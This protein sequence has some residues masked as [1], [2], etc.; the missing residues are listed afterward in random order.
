MNGINW[1]STV[2]AFSEFVP[3]DEWRSESGTRFCRIIYSRWER[4][5]KKK[6][7]W[8]VD[9]AWLHR[10]E[11]YFSR[12]CQRIQGLSGLISV[13]TDEQLST[14]LE[15]IEMADVM[16]NIISWTMFSFKGD[17]EG[18]DWCAEH[19]PFLFPSHSLIV[20]EKNLFNEMEFCFHSFIHSLALVF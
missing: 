20:S 15:L 8:C 1:D 9:H 18:G 7:W 5:M 11:S 6:C 17:A 14:R 16:K 3:T 13:P 19:L 10:E 2:S 12:K 4:E